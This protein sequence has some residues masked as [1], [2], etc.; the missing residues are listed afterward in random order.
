MKHFYI[1]KFGQLKRKGNTIY[2][3]YKENDKKLR[4][5][6]PIKTID[7]LF[8]FGE[9]TTNSKA[10]NFLAYNRIPI[11]FFN[12]YGF[13]TGSFMPRD[14]LLSGFL[15]VN[16]VKFYLDNNL[17]LE[18]AKEIVS[19]AI[20]NTIKNLIYYKKQG[21]EVNKEIELL[22]VLLQKIHFVKSISELMAIEGNSKKIYYS[23]FETLLGSSFQL[24]KRVKRPPNNMINSLISFGNSLLYTTSLSA[25]YQTQLNPTISFLHEPG[26]RRFSLSLDIA[27]IFKPI[28]VDKVIFNLVNNKMIKESYFLKELN[29][30][31]LNE[32]GKR[33][34]VEEFEK[35]LNTVIKHKRMNRYV[36]YKTLI[37]LECYKLI[38]HLVGDEKY[39]SFKMLW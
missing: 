38:K 27:E 23:T 8:I 3:E 21:K 20:H 26:E 5:S 2:F 32:W 22:K 30:V 36:S 39:K 12:Y 10:L 29:F 9:I 14:N 17:R 35:R 25:I 16:Q 31:Y 19:G 13:Y 4:K 37:R 33:V 6:L 34:F 28:I 1:F 18:I 7:S 15:L 24:N 11:H